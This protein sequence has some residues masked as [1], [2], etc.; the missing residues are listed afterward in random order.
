MNP[1]ALSKGSLEWLAS[2]FT[3]KTSSRPEDDGTGNTAS[4]SRACGAPGL[5]LP[6]GLISPNSAAGERVRI[7]L[8]SRESCGHSIKELAEGAGREPKRYYGENEGSRVLSW[9]FVDQKGKELSLEDRLALGRFL[10]DRWGLRVEVGPVE[11]L[12]V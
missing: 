6:N 8:A 5:F 12:E 10:M 1:L 2:L 4:F 11:R 7:F 9:D 3:R